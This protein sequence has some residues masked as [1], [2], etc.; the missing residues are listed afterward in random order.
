MK[1]ECKLKALKVKYDYA[2]MDKNNFYCA[3]DECTCILHTIENRVN[4]KF[5]QMLFL[6]GYSNCE[7][8]S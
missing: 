2:D 7:D 3:Q 8:V 5:G 4:I 6:E 1:L